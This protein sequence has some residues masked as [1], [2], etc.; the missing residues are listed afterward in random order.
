MM[1]KYDKI[2]SHPVSDCKFWEGSAAILDEQET[3]LD[4]LILTTRIHVFFD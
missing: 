4:S 3:D 1:E 2:L